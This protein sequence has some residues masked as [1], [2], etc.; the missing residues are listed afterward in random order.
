MDTFFN[1]VIIENLNKI[2]K[3]HLGEEYLE[4]DLKSS[5]WTTNFPKKILEKQLVLSSFKDSHKGDS[6]S[7]KE[8]T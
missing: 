7:S 6:F 4:I 5:F 3:E 2:E 1:N 8:P